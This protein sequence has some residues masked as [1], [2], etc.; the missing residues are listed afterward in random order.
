MTRQPDPNIQ[1][2]CE[3]W[4]EY[5]AAHGDEVDLDEVLAVMDLRMSI[6][7]RAARLAALRKL[8]KRVDDARTVRHPPFQTRMFPADDAY[9]VVGTN[10]RVRE[11]TAKSD[12]VFA[13]LN[14]QQANLM[15]ATDQFNYSYLLVMAIEPYLRQGMTEGEAIIAYCEDH[16]DQTYW[17]IA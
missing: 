13:A 9:L 11:V 2:T 15:A 14:L 10:Q 3:I 12:E 7:M 6:D 16:P 4:D 1:I 17:M 5:A 8:L